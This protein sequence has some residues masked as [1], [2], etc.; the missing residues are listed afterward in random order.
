[1]RAKGTWVLLFFLL[2]SLIVAVAFNYAVRDIF[3]W[4][5]I[6]NG[7][8]LGDS[9]RLSTLI[10]GSLALVLGVFFGVF[11]SKSRNY[12]EQCVVEFNKVAWS[13]WKETKM[14]TFTVVM[15]SLIAAVILGAFDSLFSWWTS[16]NLFIW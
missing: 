7:A 15:V 10:A 4:L 12:V 5:Q 8:I 11:Y 13:E 9:F 1:M 16:H 2:S 3:S 14:G 6:D